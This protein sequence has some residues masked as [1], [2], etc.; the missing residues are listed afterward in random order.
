MNCTGWLL[1]LYED[2]EDGLVLWLL[3]EERQP[4][5]FSQPFPTTLYASGPNARLRS[6]W[7]TLQDGDK[8]VQL[9]RSERREL[10]AGGPI[11]VLAV[12]APGPLQAKRVFAEISTSFPDLTY[13]DADLSPNL[14]HAA[15]Y[16]T[17]PLARVQVEADSHGVLQAIETPDSPW[18]IE[19][20]PAPLRIMTLEPD[21][22]PSRKQPA[23]VQI[24]TGSPVR[25]WNLPLEP[26]RPFLVNLAALLHRYD[27]DLILSSW[28]D[29]WLLPTL[30]QLSQS[31]SI[32]L[33]LSRDPNRGVGR[34]KERSYFSYG[35]VMHIGQQMHLFGRLHIDIYNAMLFHDYGL[36]GI[37]E[38]ARVSSLPIQKVAR[39]SPGSG[40]SAMQIVV[41]LR[42]EIL[43]PWR[44]Q[45][46]EKLKSARDLIEAD[47]GGLVYAPIGGLHSDVAELDYTSLYP[48]CITTQSLSP[49]LM[50]IAET[51]D[52]KVPGTNLTVDLT[53]EGLIPATIEPLLQKRIA[54]KTKIASL[55]AWDPRKSLYKAQ[56]AAQKWLLVTCFG[57]LGY[58][59]ARFGRIEAHM[60]TT[61]CGREAL[62][63][64]K[65]TAEGLGFRVLG[66]YVDAIW[67]TQSGHS[68]PE[69]FQPLLEAITAR[70]HLPITLEGVY[71]WLAFL[72][73]R[74]EPRVSVA[75]RYFGAFQDGSTKVRGIELRRRD[76]P[77]WIAQMQEEL[78]AV[79]AKASSAQALVTLLPELVVLLKRKVK[80]LDSGKVPLEDLVVTQKLSR[81][82]DEYKSPS[83]AAVAV[84]QLAQ[85]GKQTSPGE[86]VYLLLTRGDPGAWAWY[87]PGP[88]EPGSLDL[89]RYRTLLIRAAWSILGPIG[90]SEESLS[91]WVLGKGVYQLGESPLPCQEPP[92]LTQARQKKGELIHNRV[93]QLLER[94]EN[95]TNQTLQG[96]CMPTRR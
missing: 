47:L 7:R 60:A 18:S 88:F 27:P 1:D 78:I 74:L 61:A 23:Q 2:L 48:A 72:P 28:G 6:L 13:F 16:G 57:Y 65:E 82:V 86:H 14:R 20:E 53:K 55:P 70:T 24:Q 9:A 91:D 31:C 81:E 32:P 63:L 43:V 10:F 64:A 35:Q 22:N 94:K 3:D 87:L 92:L 84:G 75:N 96:A 93:R 29:T 46:G 40:I 38:S 67:V 36:E 19:H 26:A 59:N 49:E 73:S 90:I 5:R 79:M 51:G 42:K 89:A 71:K 39:S 56:A 11:P 58:K 41:A 62:L 25:T 69:D 66:L 12:T 80:D 52:E 50:G 21:A 45:A 33:H 17:F 77:A 95:H 44:K 8:P 30:I 4:H 15:R 68:R 34:K 37:F 83:P 76:T 54:L 85:I